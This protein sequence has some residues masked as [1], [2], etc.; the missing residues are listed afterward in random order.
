MEGRV[1]VLALG[2]TIAM[3]RTERGVVVRLTA[4][5]LVDAVPGLGRSGIEVSVRDVRGVPSSSLTFADVAA[6]LA[7]AEDAVRAG[8]HGVVVTQGTD[9]LEEVAFALDLLWRHDAPLVVTG[10]MR[11][12]MLAGADGPANVLAAALVAAAPDSRRRGAL[13]VMNDE[14]HA[15]RWVRKT[16]STSPGAFASAPAGPVGLVVEERVRFTAAAARVPELGLRLDAGRAAAVRTAV[17]PMVLGDD[18]T[19]ARAVG[20]V[21]DGLVVAAFG[22]G[23]VPAPVAEVLTGLAAAK[24]VVLASRTGAGPVLDATYT[25]PG[26]E[27]DL[28]SHALVSAGMLDPLKAR[29]LLHLLIAAGHSADGVRAALRTLDPAG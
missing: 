17:V 13:V 21:V 28:L 14:I 23:H 20:A 5:D 10:A 18:G 19:V 1:A 15:A 22:V 7:A 2:G 27:T 25:F 16:H 8:A 4:A 29:L 12:P 26:S 24:P 6:T 3:T 11:N 9:S